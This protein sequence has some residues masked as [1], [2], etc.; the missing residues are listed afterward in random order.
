[1]QMTQLIRDRAQG[2]NVN[3][4]IFHIPVMLHE[5]IEYLKPKSGDIFVDGTLGLGGHAEVILSLIGKNGRLIGIDRDAQALEIAKENLRDYQEQCH[6]FHENYCHVDRILAKLDIKRVNGILLD[7]GLSSFQLNDPQRGFSFLTEGPLDMRMD[8]DS[9]ISAFD[10]VNSL[11]ER[12]IASLLRDFG[13]ERW[14]HRIARYIVQYRSRKL[15]ET[16]KELSDIVLH[17]M[18]R[19]SKRG[20]IHPATRTFQAFR[21]AVNRELEGLEEALDKCVDALTVGGRI[22]VIAF[23]SLEDKIVKQTFR[24]LTKSR[25]LNLILKKPLRPSDK[26]AEVNARSRSA[27]LRV[28][29]RI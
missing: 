10:L 13:Q 17:A 4:N 29:E 25:R 2:K 3:K 16:T 7:L 5:V 24:G 28:A 21:I 27:R 12:E 20:K 8:Q 19:H 14:H 15:I 9:Y 18:P 1:M 23:H 6:F 22:G 11:S 26:E